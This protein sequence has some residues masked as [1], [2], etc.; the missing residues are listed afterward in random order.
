MRHVEVV[1]VDR[2]GGGRLVGPRDGALDVPDG[3]R[4][5]HPRRAE[6]ALLVAVD[7]GQ[8]R[9]RG[10]R[11]EQAGRLV[12]GPLE[13]VAVP[14]AGLVAAGYEDHPFLRR[15][16]RGWIR[17]QL[18]FVVG[19]GQ[20]DDFCGGYFRRG[21]CDGGLDGGGDGGDGGG[22]VAAEGA[23]PVGGLFNEWL[24]DVLGGCESWQGEGEGV[25]EMHVCGVV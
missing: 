14:A 18:G 6:H 23:E 4:L 13:P 16:G 25:G 2:A 21:G 9:R 20:W 7:V 15:L 11:G 17:G 8:V 12:P 1:D 10:V 5:R 24:L 3:R 22:D 19:H